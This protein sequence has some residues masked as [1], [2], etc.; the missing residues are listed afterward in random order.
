MIANERMLAERMI[1]ARVD[2]TSHRNRHDEDA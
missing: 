1:S 2:A